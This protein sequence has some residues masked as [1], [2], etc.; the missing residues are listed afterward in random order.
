MLRFV[1]DENFNG[2]VVRG[3]IRRQADLDIVRIQ[4]AGL[5]GADDPTVLAWAAEEGRIFLT[6]DRKTMPDFAYDRVRTGMRMPG[7]FVASDRLPIGQLIDDILLL[8]N[9]SEPIE[10]ED[11]VLYLPL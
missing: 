9:G 2:E 10:W 11:V 4:D 7:V 6:H 5:L 3:L 8:A 1:S